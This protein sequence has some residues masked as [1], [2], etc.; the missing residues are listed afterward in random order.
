MR[1]S[2]ISHW[3]WICRPLIMDHGT[4]AR[5]SSGASSRYFVAISLPISLE[6]DGANRSAAGNRG[7]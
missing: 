1:G 5:K 7:R 6:T 3:P 2:S 4:A